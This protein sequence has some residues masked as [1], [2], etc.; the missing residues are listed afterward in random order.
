MDTVCFVRAGKID[1]LMSKKCEYGSD[2][3]RKNQLVRK[4]EN[5]S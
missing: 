1:K 5:F 3:V 4:E 2:G